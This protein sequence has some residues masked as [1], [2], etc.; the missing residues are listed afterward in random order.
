MDERCPSKFEK[1]QLLDVAQAWEDGRMADEVQ[2]HYLFQTVGDA[3]HR[4]HGSSQERRA[5]ESV[6]AAGH[7]R[8]GLSLSIAARVMQQVRLALA[9]IDLVVREAADEVPGI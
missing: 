7:P 9:G 5:L 6:W 8:E 4:N 1:L 2:A 3:L